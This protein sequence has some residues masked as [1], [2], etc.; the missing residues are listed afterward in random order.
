M[1]DK[2]KSFGQIADFITNLNLIRKTLISRHP[3]KCYANQGDRGFVV[4]VLFINI[5]GKDIFI[6]KPCNS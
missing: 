4:W 3:L 2:D 5:Q 1:M 6:P